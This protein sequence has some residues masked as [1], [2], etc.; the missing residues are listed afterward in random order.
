M[1]RMQYCVFC[2]FLLIC[3]LIS[4]NKGIYSSEKA[5]I[6]IQKEKETTLLSSGFT[7][8]ASSLLSGRIAGGMKDGSAGIW[9]PDGV[10]LAAYGAG[11]YKSPVSAIAISDDGSHVAMAPRKGY[12]RLVSLSRRKESAW[13]RWDDSVTSMTFSPGGKFLA[14]GSLNG[15]IKLWNRVNQEMIRWFIGHELAVT[16]LSITSSGNLM[17]SASWDRTVRLWDVAKGIVVKVLKKPPGATPLFYAPG[18][19][20]ASAEVKPETRDDTVCCVAFSQDGKLLAGGARDGTVAVWEIESGQTVKSAPLQKNR[21]TSLA[22]SG[23][24]AFL[25]CGASDGT[26]RIIQ[27][28]SDL[29]SENS[30]GHRQAVAFLRPGSDCRFFSGACDGSLIQWKVSLEPLEKQEL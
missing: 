25:I 18:H 22:F 4:S 11:Y 7:C 14:A 2:F 12:V 13:L 27:V 1:T 6:L 21:I 29:E 28:R 10:L 24:G 17:A 26:I 23:D 8:M 3:L 20:Q 5:R 15:D 16:S 9:S 30:T 19:G